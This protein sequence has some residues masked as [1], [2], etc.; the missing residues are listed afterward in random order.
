[1]G[2]RDDQ[3]S[4]PRLPGPRFSQSLERGLAIL[5]CFTGKRTV[6]GIA[7]M[8]D[9]LGLSRPTTHRYA[10]TLVELGYLEQD[11]ARKYRLAARVTDLGMSAI[12]S[13]GLREHAIGHL[14][15]LAR[16]TGFSAGLAVLNAEK[17]L[18]VERVTGPRVGRNPVDA[19]LVIGSQAPAW[20]TAAGKILLANLADSERTSLL[21]KID[22]AGAGPEA[23]AAKNA[24]KAELDRV[25]EREVAIDDREQAA[26]LLA[27]AAP[28]CGPEG[29]VSAAIDL[30]ASGEMITAENLLASHGPLLASTA[31][32]LSGELGYTPASH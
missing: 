22:L 29:E 9:Q 17:V 5:R 6:L 25:R 23:I 4:I 19:S 20:R 27:I 11:S 21:A 2:G 13:T 16:T 10:V 24:L 1:M 26:D 30:L 14:R 8:A 15:D 32:R 3:G 7:D 28:I 12:D 31:G 18:Y